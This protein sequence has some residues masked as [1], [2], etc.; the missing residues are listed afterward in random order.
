[1]IGL[2]WKIGKTWGAG[3][4]EVETMED[5]KSGHFFLEANSGRLDDGSP[6]KFDG[7]LMVAS[8]VSL[9]HC[10]CFQYHPSTKSLCAPPAAINGWI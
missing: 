4:L 7:S 5:P 2:L 8:T 1:M 6:S 10:R 3:F 9:F